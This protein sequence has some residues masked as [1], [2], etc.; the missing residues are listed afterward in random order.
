[1][2]GDEVVQAYIQ[3]PDLERMPLKELKGFKRVHVFKGAQQAVTI[4]I[5]VKELQKWDMSQHAWKIYP[6]SYKLVLGG[7]SMD[8][9]FMGEFRVTGK[10]FLP[11]FE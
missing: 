3:Y 1:M 5:P 8:N 11:K 9:K 6:G 7:N 2:D 10:K 4:N